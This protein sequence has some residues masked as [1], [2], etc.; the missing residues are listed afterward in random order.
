MLLFLGGPNMMKLVFLAVFLTAFMAALLTAVDPYVSGWKESLI[1]WIQSYFFHAVIIVAIWVVSFLIYAMNP[2]L[3]YTLL[4]ALGLPAI[5]I[6]IVAMAKL[7]FEMR[8]GRN[9][10]ILSHDMVFQGILSDDTPTLQKGGSPDY[11]GTM[12]MANV[13]LTFIV[14]GMLGKAQYGIVLGTT[15]LEVKGS[16]WFYL[17]LP[18]Y[19]IICLRI[20][21]DLKRQKNLPMKIKRDNDYLA[22]EISPLYKDWRRRFIGQ[23]SDYETAE[24]VEYFN[25]ETT[26]TSLKLTNTDIYKESAT[27]LEFLNELKGIQL[28]DNEDAAKQLNFEINI[29]SYKYNSMRA[30]SE[31]MFKGFNAED[32]MMEKIGHLEGLLD[33][34]TLEANGQTVEL[35]AIIINDSGVYLIEVKNYR[36][37][38]IVFEASGMAYRQNNDKSERL[39]ILDQ[40]SRARNMIRDIIGPN[41]NIYNVIVFA[42]DETRIVDHM[43]HENIKVLHM[44]LLSFLFQNG[45]NHK[46]ENK[47]IKSLLKKAETRERKYDCYDVER[48]KSEFIQAIDNDIKSL[49]ETLKYGQDLRLIEKEI[50]NIQSKINKKIRKYSFTPSDR[51]KIINFYKERLNEDKDKLSYYFEKLDPEIIHHMITHL[52]GAKQ[53]LIE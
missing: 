23:N 9:Y 2:F 1:S 49:G 36:A 42:D 35:D 31:N 17:L 15:P 7:G 13:A 26:D 19:I 34:I 10:L 43:N 20:F 46:P 12:I 4:V 22:T 28:E 29:D 16:A 25:T 41:I 21:K 40:V 32:I 27:M 14:I 30:F 45:T 6:L 39:D 50:K 44:D 33:N 11:T 38:T 53:I 5:F 51:Q 37:D 18:I 48:V 3:D 8:E 47:E 52:E 24:M